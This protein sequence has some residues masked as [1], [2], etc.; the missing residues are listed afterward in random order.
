M[1]NPIRRIWAQGGCVLNS[2]LWLPSGFS[3]E[4]MAGLGF[5]ALTVDL[6]HGLADAAD[7]IAL[8]QAM[9]G[10]PVA[11]M[12]R[13]PANDAAIIGRVL[14]GGAVGVICP[15][16]NTAE[17]AARFV[18][19]CRYPPQGVRSYGPIR[20]VQAL[21]ADYATAAAGDILAFAMIE[22]AE[23]MENLEAIAATPGLDG[24]YVGPAD[25]TLGLT[26]RRHRIGFDRDEPEMVQAILRI[27][28][29]AHGAGLRVALHCGS[30]DYARR[31]RDWGFD[32]LTLSG[33]SA[34]LAQA[35]A[36]AVAR[37]R[38]GD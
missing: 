15:L 36:Q 31:A 2:F 13:V 20:A 27:R 18:A 35:A 34:F 12:A 25:L 23:G 17:E 21:G 14:D 7:A 33:D 5:D 4:V 19:A 32:M 26:G 24:L 6:Q 16:V 29:A 37:F 10:R 30:P 22:T 9:L 8:F 28:D 3:A 11:P 38:D 1:T